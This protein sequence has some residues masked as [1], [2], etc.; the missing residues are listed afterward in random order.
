MFSKRYD[1]QE[2][3]MKPPKQLKRV[4]RVHVVK[5]E[6][7]VKIYGSLYPK[8]EEG[9]PKFTSFFKQVKIYSGSDKNLLYN[10]IHWLSIVEKTFDQFPGKGWSQLSVFPTWVVNWQYFCR[11]DANIQSSKVWSWLKSEKNRKFQEGYKSLG[12]RG[13]LGVCQVEKAPRHG[14]QRNHQRGWT[15]QERNLN[16]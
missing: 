6:G 16:S 3:Y 1:V 13:I 8:P 11:L 15:Y 7:K 5:H 10:V 2:I 9:A 14:K 12:L 4:L